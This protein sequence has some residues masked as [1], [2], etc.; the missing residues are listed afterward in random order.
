MKPP[1]FQ[2]HDPSDLDEAFQLLANLENCLTG[3]CEERLVDQV[4]VEN[5]TVPADGLYCE[6]KPNSANDGVTD[7]AALL[8]GR[9][10]AAGETGG[11]LLFRVGDAVSSRDIHA[12]IFDSLRLCVTF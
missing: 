12:A 3:L 1:P 4:V 7:V 6:L 8:E 5:G 10:Q 9:A 2:Y 11:F